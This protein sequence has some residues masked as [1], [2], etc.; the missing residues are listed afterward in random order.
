MMIDPYQAKANL[1]CHAKLSFKPLSFSV[2][3]GRLVAS[4]A[5]L[6]DSDALYVYPHSF[7][8]R[9]VLGAT[10]VLSTKLT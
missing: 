1:I 10:T 9:H 6:R 4:K 8:Y 2:A 3:V 5:G 7:T